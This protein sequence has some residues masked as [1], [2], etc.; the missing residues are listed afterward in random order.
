MNASRP[1]ALLLDA[2]G[3][4]ITLRQTVGTT[5][6][7]FAAR[8][9][10][11]VG[12][13]AIDHAFPTVLKEAPPLAFDGLT[14]QALREAELGWWGDRIDATLKAA[15]GVV[16]PAALH[17]ELFEHFA[18]PSIWKVYD[19]VPDHLRAWSEAGLQ[20]AVVSNFDSRLQGL[21]S[22]LDLA[23]WLSV[24]VVSSSAGAAKPSPQ[25]F[26]L[27]LEKLELQP[28]QAWHVGD[29]P[30]DAL[31]ARAAGLRCLMVQRS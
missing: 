15:G 19:D 30:E 24:V 4:M 20:L 23:R 17:L 22:G 28:D 7:A 31:G 8:H 5:Y 21:L 2:V 9:G 13:A 3:T 6:S 18:D 25:P 26:R 12:A 10:I 11:E 1:L 16:A 29:S 14:G 27:A